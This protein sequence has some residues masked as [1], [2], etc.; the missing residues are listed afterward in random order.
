MANLNKV[1]L[2]GN[3]T[4][5]PELRA[6][7]G[8][9]NVCKFGLAINRRYTTQQGQQEETTFVDMTAFGRQAEVIQQYC[10]KGKPL[11]VEGRLQF[12]TW[13]TKDGQKRSKLEVIVE[14]FQF[15]GA[16]AGAGAQGGGGS[17]SGGG[18]AR[19]APASSGDSGGY[20]DDDYGADGEIPF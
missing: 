3:L 17:M 9:S 4:R 1:F 11:F 2:I 18:M 14:N 15:L 7:Q 16:G 10:T 6:T 19:G 8:G 13:E 5:D 20:G 12:S